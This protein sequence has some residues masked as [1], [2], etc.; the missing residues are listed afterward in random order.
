MSYRLKLKCLYNFETKWIELVYEPLKRRRSKNQH[1]KNFH[2]SPSTRRQIN[3]QNQRVLDIWSTLKCLLGKN[4]VNRFMVEYNK[5]PD[6]YPVCGKASF[7]EHWPWLSCC[8]PVLSIH[9]LGNIYLKWP[10]ALQTC[11]PFRMIKFTKNILRKGRDHHK[12]KWQE[13]AQSKNDFSYWVCHQQSNY[14][15]YV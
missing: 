12:L 1:Q 9:H 6:E 13:A 14:L 5:C 15:C 11:C 10:C 7:W 4:M 8:W 2:I 3:F